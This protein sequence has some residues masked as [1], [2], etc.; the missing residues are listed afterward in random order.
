MTKNLVQSLIQ[1]MNKEKVN[2]LF[3]NIENL[4]A[5]SQAIDKYSPFTSLDLL[6]VFY[7][8]KSVDF[9][10]HSMAV[11]GGIFIA[12]FYMARHIKANNDFSIYVYGNPTEKEFQAI[13]KLCQS[14]RLITRSH[15]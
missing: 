2:I 8:V 5:W 3:C 7:G 1:G 9:K 11:G 10:K 12:P 13:Q 6:R 15:E 14:F 4:D